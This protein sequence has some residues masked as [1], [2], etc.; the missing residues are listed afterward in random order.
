M[1]KILNSLIHSKQSD[2]KEAFS[3]DTIDMKRIIR[4]HLLTLKLSLI[5]D[6]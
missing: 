6:H 1:I 3:I 4:I 5:Q 2:H